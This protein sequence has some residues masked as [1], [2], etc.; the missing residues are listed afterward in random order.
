MYFNTLPVVMILTKMFAFNEF[1]HLYF[2]K[3]KCVTSSDTLSAQ[4]IYYDTVQ[5]TFSR[6]ETLQL[7]YIVFYPHTIT[8][9]WGI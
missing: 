1:H 9:F 2:V 8:P 7:S 3:L 6:L 5:A 4:M